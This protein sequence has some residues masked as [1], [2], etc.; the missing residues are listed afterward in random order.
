MHWQKIFVASRLHD[1]FTC[2]VYHYGALLR[3]LVSVA[4]YVDER[5]DD[6]VESV[7]VVVVDHQLASVI[8]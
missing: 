3:L 1:A 6:I 8:G 5:L 2:V 4:A 7:I